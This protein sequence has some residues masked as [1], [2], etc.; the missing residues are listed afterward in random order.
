MTKNNFLDLRLK[1]KNLQKKTIC[2]NSERSEQFLVTEC[3][4]NWKFLRYDELGKLEFKLDKIIGMK[5]A[6][7][8][9]LF[10]F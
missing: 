10:N 9:A 2:S 4:F 5:L 1:A 6:G 3:F 7:I 8:L